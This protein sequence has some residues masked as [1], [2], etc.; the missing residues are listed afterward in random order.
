MLI[1]VCPPPGNHDVLLA[2]SANG[3]VTLATLRKV[4]GGWV[5]TFE[6]GAR[7]PG[8]HGPGSLPW[9]KRQVTGFLRSR[10]HRLVL[11]QERGSYALPNGQPV[12]HLQGNDAVAAEPSHQDLPWVGKRKVRQRRRY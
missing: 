6:R 3:H 8:P 2:Q 1:W 9:A 5:F 7:D 10:M 12:G 4:D 11:P